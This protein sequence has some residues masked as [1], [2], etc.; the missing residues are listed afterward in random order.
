M[1]PCAAALEVLRRHRH[2]LPSSDQGGFWQAAYAGVLVDYAKWE[3]R[4][5]QR[6]WAMRHIV[7]GL[8]WVPC[9]CGRLLLGLLLAMA[10]GQ[11][12]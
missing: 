2:L 1:K 3:Y 10:L 6:F 4:R 8:L 7:E 12:L 11:S 5:G 9:R